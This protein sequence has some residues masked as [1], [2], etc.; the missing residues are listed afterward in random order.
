MGRRSE[1]WGGGAR[2]G[3][4]GGG[5]RTARAMKVWALGAESCRSE[6]GLELTERSPG[7]RQT[8]KREKRFRFKDWGLSISQS[9][10]SIF[11]FSNYLAASFFF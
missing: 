11:S 3:G 5:A 7:A 4:R 1:E 2:V 8:L 6:A 9:C 10:F